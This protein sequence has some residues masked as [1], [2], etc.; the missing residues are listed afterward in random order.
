MK[1]LVSYVENGGC[2][3]FGGTFSSFAKVPHIAPLF[4]EFGLN[5]RVG[6]YSKD[7][8]ELNRGSSKIAAENAFLPP[9]IHLKALF[10]KGVEPQH[11]IYRQTRINHVDQTT[12]AVGQVKGG[13]VGYI[14][15]V[16]GDTCITPILLA[17]FNL[18][19]YPPLTKPEPHK[20]V[21]ILVHADII[22]GY[23]H[24]PLFK[25]LK[26]RQVEIITDNRFSDSRLADLLSSPD[27]LG[28]LILD[29]MFLMPKH[30][31]LSHKVAAYVWAGGTVIFC[32]D[33]GAMAPPDEFGRFI[34]DNFCLPWK[35]SSVMALSATLNKGSAFVKQLPED[36]R[37]EVAS[38]EGAFVL[39]VDGD[40][41]VYGGEPEPEMGSIAHVPVAYSVVGKGHVAYFGHDEIG[42][43]DTGMMLTMLGLA[44]LS[45]PHLSSQLTQ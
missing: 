19:T 24:T 15:D 33:F 43:T 22:D 44:P 45:R 25:Q 14:G 41:V 29:D 12:I 35:M 36:M 42:E 38:Y 30:K 26:E 18:F 31:W 23:E 7:T 13:T 27:L 32:G 16:D 9:E 20:F 6:D 10:L 5:W 11:V 2:L 17:M 3:V 8:L 40:A 1:K 21:I 4:A 28:I 39:G 37:Q 34:T